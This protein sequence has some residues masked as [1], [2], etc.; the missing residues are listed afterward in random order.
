MKRKVDTECRIFQEKWTRSY[1]FTEIHGKPLCLVCLQ[2]V[3]VLKEYNIRRHYETLHGE[4]YNSL[5]GQLRREKINE[6]LVGL[7]KQQSTF[8]QSREVSEA[9]VKASYLI[10]SEIA[11][12][13]KPYSDGEFVKTCMM[14]AAEL[15]CPQKRQ[16]FANI[17]L[18]RNTIAERIS[19]LSADLDNQLKQRVKSFVAFSIAIDES[20][21]ITDVAQLAIFIR[22]VNETLTVSEEFLELVPMTDTTTAEDIFSSVVGALDRVGVDWSRAVSLATDGAPS[23]IGKKAGVVTKFREKVQALNGGDGFWTF[24]CILQ[25]EALCCKSLKMDHIMQVVVGTVNFIRARGLNHRQFDSLLSDSNI[26]HSLPYHTEVRWLSRGAVLR[27]FFD[28]REEIG[29]LMEKKGKPNEQEASGGPSLGWTDR[30]RTGRRTCVDALEDDQTYGVPQEAGDRRME[31]RA[32]DQ[33]PATGKLS[34]RPVSG[35]EI[36]GAREAGGC[37]SQ[38]R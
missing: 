8:T 28:L 15:V 13:S 36:G 11:L 34:R 27:R 19:E 7:R 24:H 25:Q 38:Y 22:G 29:Q 17:S 33:R 23:M 16:A 18:T 37:C 14:K 30:W 1:L 20:T 26:T 35:L 9:A 31:G 10:A 5:Q 3:S 32:G 2:Q 6:L 21:D 4:K 12:A